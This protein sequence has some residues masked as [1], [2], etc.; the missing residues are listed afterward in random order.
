MRTLLLPLLLATVPAQATVNA[1]LDRYTTTAGN[2]I[3]LTLESDQAGGLSPDLSPLHKEFQILGSKKMSITSKTSDNGRQ[4]TAR[5]QVLLRPKR[6]GTLT[7]PPIQLGSESTS[8]MEVIVTRPERNRGYAGNAQAMLEL[9]TDR[10]EV[11]QKSQLVLTLRLSDSLALPGTET[12]KA[13]EL[14]GVTLLPAGPVSQRQSVQRGQIVNLM[15]R[16]FL[17]FPHNSGPLTIPAQVLT[18]PGQDGGLRDIRSDALNINVLPPAAQQS[19]G[20]WL[21][22]SKVTLNESWDGNT[23]LTVGESIERTLTLTATGIRADDL[24]ALM[25]LTNELASIDVID[26]QR[27]EQMSGQGLLST[28]TETVRITPLERGEITL[29]AISLPWWNT[30]T[31]RSATASLAGVQLT[32]QPATTTSTS[33]AASASGANSTDNTTAENNADNNNAESSNGWLYMAFA[34]VVVLAGAAFGGLQLR[35]RKSAQEA[36]EREA[37]AAP[38]ISAFETLAMACHQTDP[39]LARQALLLWAQEFWRDQPPYSLEDML[40]LADEEALTLLVEDLEQ[41][42]EEGSDNWQGDMLLQTVSTIRQRG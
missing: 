22:A 27:N 14:K 33:A 39:Y 30:V 41:H 20:F 13:P 11:Y 23:T 31:D 10:T 25:P 1:Y 34:G 18:L 8:E 12:L 38:E 19:R 28:R 4:T 3:R 16:R 21:P 2:N 17:L 5:W 37:A 29:P 24:P 42:A 40:Y 9:S 26:I 15:E 32:A 36:A 7:L 6:A 35:R